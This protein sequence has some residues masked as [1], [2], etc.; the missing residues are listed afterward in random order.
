MD[1][2]RLIVEVYPDGIHFD[3]DVVLTLNLKGTS[4]EYR[5]ADI[6]IAWYNPDTA[7]WQLLV[8]NAKGLN[9]AS[10]KLEHFSKYGGL[11]NGYN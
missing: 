6:T 7:M 8:T 3:R 9:K 4:A 10:T 2:N 11:I 1:P 5:A